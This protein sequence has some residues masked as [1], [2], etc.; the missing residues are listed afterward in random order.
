MAIIQVTEDLKSLPERPEFSISEQATL[1]RG[2]F[3]KRH[4]KLFDEDGNKGGKG[5]AYMIVSRPVQK[6]WDQ[7]LDFDR[8]HQ[9]FPSVKKCKIYRQE[10]ND[11]YSEFILSIG[12]VIRIHYFIK[13]TFFPDQSRMIWEVDATKKND[14]KQSIGMWTA[15][16]LDGDKSLVGY[17]VQI[18]SGRP[19][20]KIIEDLAAA[21]GL[22][23]VMEALKKRVES[24][25]RWKG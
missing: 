23:K 14:F 8:Y 12:F 13:H 7:V 3:V 21:S 6:V 1:D 9:F 19:V 17:T 15:W 24:D 16:P 20:P 11:I 4:E 10:D 5:I 2:N 25:G 18:D 22:N